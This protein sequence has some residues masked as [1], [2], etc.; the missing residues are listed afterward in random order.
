MSRTLP[1]LLLLALPVH[2]DARDAFLKARETLEK[3]D[4]EE[5]GAA[6]RDDLFGALAA[7]DHPDAVKAV[8]EAVGRYGLY[9][10]TLEMKM[11]QIQ[12]KLGPLM[13]KTAMTD[14]AIGLRNSYLRQ[15]KKLEEEWSGAL[16]SLDKLVAG[17]GAWA[18]E[19]T[20]SLA[21][22][23][24]PKRPTWR[25]RQV[26][27]LACAEWHKRLASD[28]LTK[29]TFKTLKDLARDEE[30]RVRRAVARALVSFRRAEALP[31]LQ[32][33]LNDDD[34]RVRAA[35]IETVTKNPSDE[36]VDMLVMRLPKEKGRL[37][38]DIIKFLQGL[39]GE[40]YQ[41]PEEWVG[42]WKGKGRRIP[43]KGASTDPNARPDTNK[44]PK[45]GHRFYGIR[46]QSSHVLY[47]IDMSGSMKKE[48]EELKR[49]PITG[50]RE[51]ETPVGGKTR[52]EVAAN[53]L[54][55]AIRN[56]Q[57]KTYFTIIFFNNSV[58]PWKMEMIE[59]TPEHKK[60]ALE[61]I[62]KVGPR[63]STYTLGALRQA[64][65]MAGAETKKG[66]TKREGP[67]IDTI[68]LLSDGGPTDA[69]MS[70]AQPMPPD[71]ILEQVA[72]WNKD[73]GVVIHT[74]AVHTDDL[75]TYFLKQLAAQNHGQFVERK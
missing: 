72:Q 66:S 1:L 2:A 30:P 73:L 15:M 46:T 67:K 47:I 63:G 23:F 49:G 34:W 31:V 55:R 56:L 9:L 39:S 40:K 60:E 57:R 8:S 33:C 70:G 42:W 59:A 17:M 65:A 68:F 41:F 45:P 58:Q 51:S 22:S 11:A 4:Y 5:L 25:V 50:R 6:E 52:W 38:D 53:E 74:I 3:A 37:A 13:D 44:K 7:Y 43:P 10:D 26:T 61:F 12:E 21:I 20:L 75:G 16:K 64:F 36:T 27:A 14:Q 71:P 69:K 28:K 24:L 35:A 62:E 48:V 18:E 29:K 54:K 32:Q 19:R